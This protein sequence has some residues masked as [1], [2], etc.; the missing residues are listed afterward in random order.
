M[1]DKR[2]TD[3]IKL[4]IIECPLDDFANLTV[5]EI[6]RRFEVCVPYLSR[7]FKEKQGINLSKHIFNEKIIRSRFILKQ[8]QKLSVK[9]IAKTLGFSS[10]DYFIQVFKDQV[11]ITPGKFRKISGG[12]YGLED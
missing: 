5:N 7:I 1:I 9:S 10:S 11:G 2:L 8:N 3:K 4:Y 6:A 12:S